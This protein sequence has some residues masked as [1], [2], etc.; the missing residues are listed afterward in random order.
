[1]CISPTK[2]NVGWVEEAKPPSEVELSEIAGEQ[3]VPA[4]YARIEEPKAPE[5][6]LQYKG[7]GLAVCP[8]LCIFICCLEQA[9]WEQK[10]KSIKIKDIKIFINRK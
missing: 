6:L 8:F 5:I 7:K 10:W 9:D 2:L 4:L 1:M 3:S